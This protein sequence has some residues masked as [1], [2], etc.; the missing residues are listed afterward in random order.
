MKSIKKPGNSGFTLIELLIVIAIIAI[1][2]VVVILAL[3]PAEL[4]KQA[5]DSNRISDMSTL[6]NAISLYLADGQTTLAT[7]YTNCYISTSTAP[8]ASNCGGWFT[9]AYT[10]TTS[11]G[12]RVVNGA[13]WLSGAT[14]V[15]FSAITSGA[16]ISQLPLDPINNASYYYAYAATSTNS[17]FKLTTNMESSKY[18]N[19]GS[20]DVE[21]TDGGSGG[22]STTAIME[23]GTN[24]AL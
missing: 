6:K 4:L 20:S 3:N 23:A 15:N 16:P 14:G 17:G 9:T 19:G 22:A 5:R 12:S 2:S 11:T 21:S 1:L 24:L 18:A 8:A 10:T 7:S 13:G